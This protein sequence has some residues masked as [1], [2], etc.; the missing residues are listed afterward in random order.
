[1]LP[2]HDEMDDWIKENGRI[3]K[4]RR[5]RIRR[6]FID[7][8]CILRAFHKAGL[9]IVLDLPI[10]PGATLN[11]KFS[12]WI[13]PCYDG[14]QVA[15]NE[16]FGVGVVPL[17][18]AQEESW[19]STGFASSIENGVQFYSCLNAEKS[20]SAASTVLILPACWLA[21]SCWTLSTER[22]QFTSTETLSIT[23]RVEI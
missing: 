17:G 21:L 4:A 7:D 12:T 23:T 11:A 8:F 5:E 10:P 15:A 13:N 20:N 2:K 6:E 14:F 22:Q 3:A 19:L 18:T 1:M 16:I 9:S